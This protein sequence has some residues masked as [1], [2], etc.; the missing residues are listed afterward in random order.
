MDLNNKTMIEEKLE[1]VLITYNRY[2]DLDNTLKQFLESPFSKCMITVLDNCS[3][4]KTPEICAKYK[5]LF[6]NMKIVRHLKNIGGNTNILRAVE[7]SSSLYTWVI[8]DD[9]SYDFSDCLDIIEAINSEKFDLISPGSPGEQEWERGLLTS[10]KKLVEKGS[11]YFV[12]RSFVPGIIFKTEL[13]DSISLMEGYTNIHN[14]LP[15]F[16]FAIKSLEDDFSI[17]LSKKNII[18]AGNHNITSFSGIYF[19]AG[20][21][22]SCSLIKDKKIFKNTV[23]TPMSGSKL[24]RRIFISITFEKI[25]GDVELSKNILTL[26][27]AI[28]S[29]FGLRIDVLIVLV[30]LPISI[31]P[32]FVFKLFLK[33]YIYLKYS[34]KGEKMPSEW[35][36]LLSEYK[37]VDPL[38]KF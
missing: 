35:N 14:L 21:I 31:M 12:A 9:D 23:Y 34:V 27:F 25:S 17:Y 10:V 26:I 28:M 4:D 5:N 13:F 1:I 22:N 19:I 16:P 29:S 30:I 6:P 15:H 33:T 8:C 20:W 11:Y 36:Y 24:L 7:T 3:D 2:K 37:T 32:R 18:E 38:R